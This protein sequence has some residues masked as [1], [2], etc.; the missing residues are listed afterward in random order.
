MNKFGDAS[1][2]CPVCGKFEFDHRGS[3]D[4]CE[5]CGWQ[6]DSF[7]EDF[8][9]EECCA[10]QMSLNQAKRAYAEGLAQLIMDNEPY[11]DEAGNLKM[12]G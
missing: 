6:D 2:L 5:V 8:P 1:H 9:D 7:Q 4:I 3:H 10:N 11:P 12:A